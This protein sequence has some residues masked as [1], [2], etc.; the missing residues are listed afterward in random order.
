ME[1]EGAL[2]QAETHYVAASEWKSA[3]QMYRKADQW[4]EAYRV[5]RTNGGV[6]AAKQVAYHWAQSLDNPEAAVK[7]LTR[8]GLLNQVVDF[9]VEAKAFEFAKELIINSGNDLKHKINEVKLKYALFLEDENRLSEAEL[10]Y[11]E[12]GKPKEAVLMY[13]HSGDF[14]EA[15]RV[16]EESVRDEEVIRD[17]LTQQA[18]HIL[19][20]G[21]RSLSEL[22]RAENLLL[23]AGRIEYAVKIYRDNGMWEEALRVA[24]QF[25]PQL[26]DS[27]K[28]EMISNSHNSDL[29]PSAPSH[30]EMASRRDKQPA[31]PDLNDSTDI[32]QSLKIAEQKGDKESVVRYTL[33]LAT[34]MV[35]DKSTAEALIILNEHNSVFILPESKKI[36]IRIASDLMSFETNASIDVQTWKLLRDT[37]F[38]VIS[39]SGSDSEQ[40]VIEKFLFVSHL[41]CIKTILQSMKNQSNAVELHSRITTSL[42]R[43]TDIVRVDKAFYEAGLVAKDNGRLEMAFVF[44]NHF[45]DLVEAIEEGELN[46]DHSDFAGTD[47][48]YEVPLPSQPFCS[49]SEHNVIEEVKSWILQTSMDSN[50]S[51]SLPLDAFRD[52][53]VYEASLVN[54]DGTRSLACLVTGYP[55][56][57]HKMLEFKPGKYAVNKD[58]WNKL[59]MLTKVS[60]SDDLKDILH[61]VGK[62][63]GNSA[64][65]R[66]SFQ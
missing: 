3:V 57:K 16:A 56:I 47:I 20:R 63:C 44:W 35:R 42:L 34:Q 8:F 41:F 50:I 60:Q 17:V 37:L 10:M 53:D 46:V 25:A 27:V 24:E 4:E 66:F 28:R 18:R 14:E 1:T 61:F 49:D 39:S 59:L 55:V 64:I 38:Q 21:K 22:N 9:A 65:A 7:L 52:G 12:A 54:G 32:R 29:Y 45:L 6:N 43:Y 15:L 62:L 31:Q 19:E 2:H 5:A 58:D 40:E 26:I 23:R 36:V 51:Q 48:P 30:S 11:T 33:V 13:L